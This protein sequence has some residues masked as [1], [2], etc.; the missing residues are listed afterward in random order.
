M[1]YK[2]KQ[3]VQLSKDHKS[4]IHHILMPLTSAMQTVYAVKNIGYI[5]F[6]QKK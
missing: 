5:Y 1:I 6:T 3:F 2:K 4:D